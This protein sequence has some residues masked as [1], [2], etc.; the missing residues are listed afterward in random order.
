MTI[1]L[2]ASVRNSLSVRVLLELLERGHKATL[3]I[4]KTSEDVGA[5]AAA[6]APE[7]II[8]PFLTVRIP[9]EVFTR[10]PTIIIHPGPPGDRGPSSLDWALISGERTWGVVA[11]E[12][13]ERFDA[14]DI[15]AQRSFAIPPINKTTLYRGLVTKYAT[16]IIFEVIEKVSRGGFAPTPQAS[17]PVDVIRYRLRLPEETRVIAWERDSTA[18]VLRKL[19][20]S[21]TQPGV[22]DPMFGGLYLYGG[23]PETKQRGAPGSII[24]FRNGAMCIGTTDGAVWVTHVRRMETNRVLEAFSPIKLPAHTVLGMFLPHLAHDT[25]VGLPERDTGTFQE[26]WYEEEHDV[27]YLHFDFYNG[28]MGVAQCGK[29]LAAYLKACTRSTKVLALMG[30][31]NFWSNGIHLN[32]IEAAS[33]PAEEAMRNLRAM[34]ELARTIITTRSK[35]IVASLFGSAGAGGAIVPLAADKVVASR[36]SILYPYYKDMGL[37]GSEY[38][39]Y[40]LPRR[41]GRDRATELLENAEPISSSTALSIGYLDAVL[42]EDGPQYTEEVRAY[43][44]ALAHDSAYGV[45]LTEKN[46]TRDH[47]EAQK[48]LRA[49]NAE[50]VALMAQ[51]FSGNLTVHGTTF[52][53]ARKQFVYR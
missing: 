52:P 20:A 42:S 24:G 5:C 13:A 15:W 41:V 3:E 50:E 37:T 11:L 22:P 40:L 39:S 34:N 4:V 46:T 25:H 53:K 35:L 45:L 12:A 36:R 33:D 19:R 51:C 9:K 49:Y 1:L 29:L 18:V 14:G 7:L 21:D 31:E 26:I 38:S 27:G 2:F 48:P 16:E 44:E 23:H 43:C 47:D 30:G 28:A 32:L 10:Y 6:H 8:C 17:L